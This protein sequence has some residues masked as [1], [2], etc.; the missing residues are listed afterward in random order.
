MPTITS[1]ANA[2]LTPLEFIDVP[3]A[4][5]HVSKIDETIPSKDNSDYIRGTSGYIDRDEHGFPA[6]SPADMDEVN[7]VDMHLYYNGTTVGTPGVDSPT[8]RITLFVGAVSKGYKVF[9]A[10]SGG[11]WQVRSFKVTPSPVL[12]KSDYDSLDIRYTVNKGTGE[13]PEMLP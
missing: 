1:Q 7:L 4:G 9:S 10:A 12:S 6:D 5:T 11:A 2:D 3:T 13:N 8:L